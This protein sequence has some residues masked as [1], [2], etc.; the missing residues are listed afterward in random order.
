MMLRYSNKYFLS[1]LLLAHAATTSTV[2]GWIVMSPI[3]QTIVSNSQT[4]TILN[5]MSDGSESV[6]QPTTFREAEILGLRFM[7][8]NKHEEA[9][10]TFKAGLK[11]PG[12]RK[13]VIRTQLVSGPSPVGGSAGGRESKDV[14]TLDEFELQAAHYN[15][16]CANAQLG[17]VDEAVG[18]LKKCFDCGFDNY[19]TVRGDPDLSNL[20]GTYEFNDLMEEYD[21]SSGGFN[22]FGFFG[23]KK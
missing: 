8:E 9:L 15:L 7:Q 2:H 1:L 11:L 19:A 13:D 22:P 21:G 16:A 3:Q 18:N 6:P 5:M 12:S 23:G 20:Q 4:T 10:E 17:N 14:Q